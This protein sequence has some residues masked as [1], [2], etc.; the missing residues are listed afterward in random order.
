MPD[1]PSREGSRLPQ[2]SARH[3]F[4]D[5]VGAPDA[6]LVWALYDEFLGLRPWKAYQQQFAS[7]Y[8]SFLKRRRSQNS[9]RRKR[10]VEQRISNYAALKHA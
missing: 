9:R 8:H 3:T 10:K 5:L 7:R 2:S 6:T 1:N 4:R